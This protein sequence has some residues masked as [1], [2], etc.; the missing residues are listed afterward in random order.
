MAGRRLVR[1]KQRRLSS[2][3][4]WL[5]SSGHARVDVVA[6]Q[7]LDHDDGIFRAVRAN[8]VDAALRLVDADDNCLMLRDS[9]GAAPIHIAFLFGHYDL[10]KRLV[11][12]C[13]PLATLT[14]SSEDQHA[15]CPYEGENI[16]HIAIIRRELELVQWLVREAPQLVRAETTGKFFGP[17]KACYFG[18]TPLLFALAS[19][20][21]DMALHIL[22]AAERLQEGPLK[23]GNA[24]PLPWI[25]TCDRF[26]NNVLHL[27]VIRD[28]PDVYDFAL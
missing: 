3:L 7:V 13:R 6:Q 27:A 26:G 10:G 2:P 23:E 20:Q 17:T 1:P 4:N 15:P 18:G 14:Y 25:F 22:E 9:V 24:D 28:L 12:R 5:W 21:I 8:D 11:L 16:L 19:N